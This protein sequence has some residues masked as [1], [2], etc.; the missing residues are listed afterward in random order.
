MYQERSKPQ[1]TLEAEEG[2]S[3]EDIEQELLDEL[4][5]PDPWELNNTARS[6]ME[7]LFFNRV[8][9]V[10]SQTFM[11]LLRRLAIRNQ[12]GMYETELKIT[13]HEKSILVIVRSNVCFRITL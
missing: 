7:L 10:G 12:F 5:I 3:Q 13:V 9:K 1:R 4:S 2:R 8:P 6:E 11:E